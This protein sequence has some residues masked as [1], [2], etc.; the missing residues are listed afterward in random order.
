M[1]L[2]KK[3]TPKPLPL[4]PSPKSKQ[5][6]KDPFPSSLL[7]T[8]KRLDLINKIVCRC[9]NKCHSKDSNLS[10]KARSSRPLQATPARTWEGRSVLQSSWRKQD[11]VSTLQCPLSCY[12]ARSFL[13]R[14]NTQ[15]RHIPP[16]GGDKE[17]RQRGSQQ[18]ATSYPSAPDTWSWMRLI[19]LFMCVSSTHPKWAL[20][21]IYST[22]LSQVLRTALPSKGASKLLLALDNRKWTR[23]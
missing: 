6:L 11:R 4:P 13:T 19:Q 15:Q 5:R 12:W 2:L 16:L 22:C 1:Q 7:N 3:R 21:S 8:A 10:F 17:E 9:L 18:H 23:W 20:R 14:W